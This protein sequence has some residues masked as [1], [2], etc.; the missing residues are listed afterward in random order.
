M[1]V[2]GD[3]AVG[4]GILSD[5]ITDRKWNGELYISPETENDLFLTAEIQ[6][7]TAI[8]YSLKNVFFDSGVFRTKGDSIGLSGFT[9]DIDQNCLYPA[10]SNFILGDGPI[11]LHHFALRNKKEYFFGLNY[12]G[13]FG[14]MRYSDNYYTSCSIFD[15]DK[16][17]IK[18][19]NL[20]DINPFWLDKGVYSA[21][22]RQSNYFVNKIRGTATLNFDILMD[23]L[24]NY[25]PS[26][27]WL[28]VLNSKNIPVSRFDKGENGKI[29]FKISS[30]TSETTDASILVK[31]HKETQWTEIK[32]FNSIQLLNDNTWFSADISNVINTDTTLM[33]LKIILINKG[34]N[35]K[36]EWI[37]EPAFIVGDYIENVEADST[38]LSSLPK[39]FAL[40]SNYPNPFNPSTVISYALPPLVKCNTESI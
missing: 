18:S 20:Y 14:E 11:A 3:G 2:F 32:K 6:T 4:R 12:R 5:L 31:K 39:Q 30:F 22:F 17:L 1:Q 8:D 15:K 33:D 35:M 13:Q 40:Y 7:D 21:Q 9:F 38:R 29:A 10:N 37:L 26:L 28:K 36:T 24:P 19:G 27:Y 23:N 16:K 34:P 25:G